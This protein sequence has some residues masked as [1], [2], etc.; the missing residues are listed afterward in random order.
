[1]MQTRH[2][3]Q[4]FKVKVDPY[5]HTVRITNIRIDLQFLFEGYIRHKQFRLMLFLQ[6]SHVYAC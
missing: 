2:G 5:T 3:P 4:Y 6:P 1:M